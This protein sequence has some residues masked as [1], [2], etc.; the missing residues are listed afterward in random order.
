MRLRSIREG[1]GLSM[2]ELATKTGVTYRT[3]Q[4]W[5]SGSTT[6]SAAHLVKLAEVLQVTTD[7]IMGVDNETKD[8]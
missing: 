3:I 2:E 1:K 7:F 8:I 5:E 6:P 4:N